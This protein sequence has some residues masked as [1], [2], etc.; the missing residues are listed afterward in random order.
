M[1]EPPER[2]QEVSRRQRSERS[3]RQQTRLARALDFDTAK[4]QRWRTRKPTKGQL[5]RLGRI[6]RERDRDFGGTMTRGR[7]A[8]II[9]EWKAARGDLAKARAKA[10]AYEAR[11]AAA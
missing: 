2:G 9:T 4:D 7:A 11:K 5:A 3:K 10:K 1:P 8:D 6:A